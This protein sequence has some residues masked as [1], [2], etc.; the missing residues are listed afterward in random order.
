MVCSGKD[1]Y[2]L[3]RPFFAI[4]LVS[5]HLRSKN[6][7]LFFEREREREDEL[8]LTW[9]PVWKLSGLS[10]SHVFG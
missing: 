5:I 10:R 7:L 9:S 6:L 1:R 2:E 4:L 8:L 3:P